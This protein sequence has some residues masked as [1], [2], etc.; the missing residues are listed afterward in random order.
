MKLTDTQKHVVELFKNGENMFITGPGGT[1]KTFLINQ[2]VNHCLETNT[3]HQICAMTG[4]AALLLNCG[5]RTIH[6]WSG[7]KRANKPNDEIIDNIDT[8]NPYVKRAW[9]QTKVLII[10]E[11]SMMSE[12]IFNLLDG[13]A[14]RVRK[15]NNPFGNMQI[16]FV[17]DFYQL[18]PVGSDE[19]PST[20]RFCF[21]SPEWNNT[22]KHQVELTHIFRQTDPIY[23]NV[24][25]EIRVGKISEESRKILEEKV[26][27]EH[28]D[29]ECA[30]IYPLKRSVDAIND[31][32]FGQLTGES[33][34]FNVK[35]HN[36]LR[37]RMDTGKEITDYDIQRC[38][39]MSAIHRQY[40]VDNLLNSVNIVH[41]LPLKI[42]TRIMCT[43]NYDMDKGICNGSQGKVLNFD[44]DKKT[45]KY[46]PI[47]EFDNGVVEIFK[48][49]I[50]QSEAYPCIGIEQLPL[51]WAW[52]IT[53]HKIQGATLNSAV[54]DIGKSIFE[55][56]QTYVALSRIKSLDG[57]YLT[58][59]ESI[60]I[61][62]NAK[63]L[64]FYGLLHA[65]REMDDAM[66]QVQ[67]EK[68]MVNE[69]KIV[70][71][72]PDK[73]VKKLKVAQSKISTFWDIKKT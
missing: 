17:G 51:I 30:Q 59:F 65:K 68:Q 69:S 23:R 19:D 35:Q 27:S 70:Q 8:S 31:K 37:S 44:Y 71:S 21:E 36:K 15:N 43:I 64:K 3:K 66:S 22:F 39:K 18:P 73:T 33:K 12:K 14:K 57:L 32:R 72:Q 63:V 50:W 49:H 67:S 46:H 24:L 6:S 54:M 29:V 60:K 5:A 20:M 40:E 56:G 34:I 62:T 47:I 38:D 45:N 13:I 10:D 4:C 52:A 25:N 9:K 41:Y 11:V 26:S 58:S 55:C 2:L 7:I 53:I 1:G 61:K 48:P 28:G 42:N 16:I